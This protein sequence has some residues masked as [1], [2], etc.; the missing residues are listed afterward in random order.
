MRVNGLGVLAPEMGRQPLMSAGGI[1][2]LFEYVEVLSKNRSSRW[3][4][5]HYKE[6]LVDLLRIRDAKRIMEIGGGRFPL[7]NLAEIA[8]FDVEYIIND[9]SA[10]ELARA[11]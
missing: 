1:P 9:V 4:W 6:V 5:H 8:P 3:A 2:P 10:S 11:P 7:F